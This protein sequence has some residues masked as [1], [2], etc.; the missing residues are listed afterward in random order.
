MDARWTRW[1]ARR[2]RALKIN[3]LT[4]SAI[5]VFGGCAQSASQA[6]GL[7]PGDLQVVAQWLLPS[8]GSS[9]GPVDAVK[10]AAMMQRYFKAE[11]AIEKESG[12]AYFEDGN[13]VGGGAFNVYLYTD[14]VDATVAQLI[15]L[16]H[17]GKIAA[18]LRIG[19]AQ[20]TDAQRKDWTYKAYYPAGL[21]RFDITYLQVPPS[22]AAKQGR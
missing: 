13:D 3:A 19:V 5:L 9:P 6:R 14:K 15:A 11:R 16:E 20:Y 2:M 22:A 10:S 12:G 7:K 17:Q 21:T 8:G 18:G 4:L 1:Q